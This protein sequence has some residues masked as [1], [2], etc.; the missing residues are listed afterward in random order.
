VK[1]AFIQAERAVF[2][3]EFMCK[4]LGVSRSGYYAW[5]KRAASGRAIADEALGKRIAG[6]HRESRG[7]YGSPR[8]HAR[9]AHEGV[10]VGRRR[11]ARLMRAHGLTVRCRRRFRKTTDS[12]HGLPVAPNRLERRFDVAAPDQAWVGDVTYVWT[13]EGWLYLA[14]MLDLFSRRVVGWSMRDSLDRQLCLDALEMAVAARQPMPGLV[15]HTDRGAQYASAEYRQALVSGGLLASMSRT[16]D[17][18]DNA[19]AES[20]FS[21]LKTELIHQRSFADATEARTAIFEYIEVFYNR[22]RAH[23]HCGYHAPA[24]YETHCARPASTP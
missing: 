3:V 17:C 6:I 13:D 24:A 19:V 14:V 18:W 9:L 4:H 23:S 22:Q 7:T 20:F 15:H 11:V 10:R 2:P 1:F 21:T 16:R 12:R 8:V 5:L